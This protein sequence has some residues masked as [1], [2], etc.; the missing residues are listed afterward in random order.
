MVTCLDRDGLQWFRMTLIIPVFGNAVTLCSR[1]LSF[2]RRMK[3]KSSNANKIIPVLGVKSK[4]NRTSR[5]LSRQAAK[6]TASLSEKVAAAAVKE[7]KNKVA[8]TIGTVD[9][10]LVLHYS[11][12]DTLTAPR[13]LFVRPQTDNDKGIVVANVP[14]F[15]NDDALKHLL[16]QYVEEG[17]VVAVFTRRGATAGF[18][19]VSAIFDSEIWRQQFFT[20]ANNSD[21]VVLED[22]DISLPSTGFKTNYNAQFK[23]VDELR[24]EVENAVSEYDT[25][26]AEK[27]REAKDKAHEEP[28]D[29]GWVTV[30]A[31]HPRAF[32]AQGRARGPAAY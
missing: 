3:P 18:R 9:Y 32:K 21:P 2:F 26:R 5:R 25:A 30:T 19:V 8:E 29:D 13:Q 4:L 23:S 11:V 20:N 24:S 10:V 6:P 7:V 1:K 17:K 16:E 22:L 12:S 15:L 27:I 31:K 14:P 28:A